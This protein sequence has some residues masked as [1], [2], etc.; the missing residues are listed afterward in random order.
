LTSTSPHDQSAPAALP[1]PYIVRYHNPRRGKNFLIKLFH[2]AHNNSTTTRRRR[3]DHVDHND[4][5]LPPWFLRPVVV[6]AGVQLSSVPSLLLLSDKA[7]LSSGRPL[8][9]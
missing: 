9:V 7:L 3:I 1:R 4:Y 5:D 8:L 6:G 2:A